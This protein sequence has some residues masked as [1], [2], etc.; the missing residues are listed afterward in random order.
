[1]FYTIR[2]TDADGIIATAA[3]SI[4]VQD[5]TGI[6]P[7][8][9]PIDK[10]DAFLY[11]QTF[12]YSGIADFDL[13]ELSDRTSN[14]TV[15]DYRIDSTGLIIDRSINLADSFLLESDFMPYTT[16]TN[17]TN[18]QLVANRGYALSLATIE[19]V[20][21]LYLPKTNTLINGDRIEFYPFTGKAVIFPHSTEQT[22][23]YQG[24]EAETI[25]L[26]NNQIVYGMVYSGFILGWLPLFVYD[27]DVTFKS[28]A[29]P[30]TLNNGVTAAY[31]F[32]TIT[33]DLIGDVDFITNGTPAYTNG[34]IGSSYL[35]DG[36][37]NNLTVI[38]SEPISVIGANGKYNTDFTI[39]FYTN[40]TTTDGSTFLQK[41]TGSG[42]SINI[43][44][45]I[46]ASFNDSI[47]FI[48]TGGGSCSANTLGSSNDGFFVLVSFNAI[49]KQ[50][51]IYV[52]NLETGLIR[53][54]QSGNSVSSTNYIVNQNAPLRLSANN[55][56]WIDG[57]TFWKRLL[58][59]DEILELSAGKQYP[60]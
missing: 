4:K 27:L 33:N 60:Y 2:V 15:D 7:L 36:S 47:E 1:M 48:L 53:D 22:F 41:S 10:V 44:Y 14:L 39:A 26:D 58:T 51:R 46:K 29:L 42:E 32:E 31:S 8:I 20:I 34:I 37:S 5:N 11:D 38:N 49:T 35:F 16:L 12:T 25:N 18:L 30:S 6:I 55:G 19:T 40:D 17:N 50:P 28:I 13:L 54:N 23:I 56:K 59:E 3:L 9:S 43:E 45:R 52:K 24:K 57:L 21:N